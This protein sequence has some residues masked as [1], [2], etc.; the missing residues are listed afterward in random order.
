MA[1]CIEPDVLLP[2]DAGEDSVTVKLDVIVNSLLLS[3]RTAVVSPIGAAAVTVTV[4]TLL[5]D[6]VL[7]D[8]LPDVVIGESV[9]L[10]VL[11]VKTDGLVGL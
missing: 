3:R 7:S 8:M 6:W 10:S 9:I 5:A 2:R 4:S 1:E 11:P